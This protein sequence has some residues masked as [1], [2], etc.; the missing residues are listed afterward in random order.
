[1]AAPIMVI[2]GSLFCFIGLIACVSLFK[3]EG[4]IPIIFLISAL[5]F[6]LLGIVLIIF[7]NKE[8]EKK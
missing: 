5:L 2:F 6:I 1:M 3:L 8:K 7:G 4:K